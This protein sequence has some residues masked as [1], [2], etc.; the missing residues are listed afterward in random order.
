MT[1]RYPEAFGIRSGKSAVFPAEVCEVFPGQVY[2]KKLDGQDTTKMLK[3]TTKKPEERL[4][5]IVKAV[6]QDVRLFHV[7]AV[8]LIS[9]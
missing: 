6:D 4:S 1:L 2:K 8:S 7:A 3:K 5:D 9:S